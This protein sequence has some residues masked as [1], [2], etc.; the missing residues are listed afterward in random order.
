MCL[1][2][3]RI[4]S[5]LSR[6]DP[7]LPL[8]DQ[9]IDLNLLNFASLH[10]RRRADGCRRCS[11]LLG[12]LMN[13]SQ[14][15]QH[16]ACC[17]LDTDQRTVGHFRTVCGA[18]GAP[19]TSL[20]ARTFHLLHCCGKALARTLRKWSCWELEACLVRHADRAQGTIFTSGCPRPRNPRW[21]QFACLR[22]SWSW[23]SVVG[24]VR[25]AALPA[26]CADFHRNSAF[27]FVP[28]RARSGDVRTW[29]AL[30]HPGCAGPGPGRARAT[31]PGDPVVPCPTIQAHTRH[32]PGPLRARGADPPAGGLSLGA[33]DTAS[34]GKD[35]PQRARLAS[36]ACGVAVPTHGAGGRPHHAGVGPSRACPA[37]RRPGCR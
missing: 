23:A 36:N 1:P 2:K 15:M 20:Q 34:G 25:Q 27:S 13:S 35:L 24:Q 32:L 11:I 7:S 30:T 16:L 4:F 31:Y 12:C 14:A 21:T 37:L 22:M 17:H 6:L 19:T 18:R 10:H 3:L 9:M 29:L 33:G 8:F 26:G 28:A 5:F